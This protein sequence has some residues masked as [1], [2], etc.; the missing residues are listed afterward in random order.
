MGF[1]RS[2]AAQ[3]PS[4]SA[5]PRLADGKPDLQGIWEAR[6]TAAED[7]EA[8]SAAAGIRAGESVIVDPPDG[9]IPYQPAAAAKQKENFAKRATA[10]PVNRCFLPGVPRVTYMHYPFQIFQTPEYVAITY[11]YVHASRTIHMKG[12]HLEDIDFWM[13]DSRGRWEGDTLVVD[14]AD[15]NPETWLDMSGNFHSEALHVVERYTRT[16]PDTLQYEATIEDPKVF[17]RPWKISM[18]L[19]RHTEKNAQ[20]YEYECHVYREREAEK[21]K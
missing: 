12:S 19:Y 8:H 10:D 6:N 1:A 13:G 20:L 7:L 14:V 18:P 16:S 15:N 9:K 5:I 11:E 4:K 21:S 2:S 17:T 3:G